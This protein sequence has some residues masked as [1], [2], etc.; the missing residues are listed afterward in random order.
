MAI[1][2]VAMS[3]N[4]LVPVVN[5]V[6]VFCIHFLSTGE[7]TFLYEHFRVT[8]RVSRVRLTVRVKM[9]VPQL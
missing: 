5:V 2:D 7:F 4:A 9:P 8:V 6:N 1:G 3:C